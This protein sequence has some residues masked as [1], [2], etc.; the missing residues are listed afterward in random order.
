MLGYDVPKGYITFNKL[1]IFSLGHIEN[2]NGNI[3]WQF[4]KLFKNDVI[5]KLKLLNLINYSNM[6]LFI[7]Q[8]IGQ[9]HKIFT[10]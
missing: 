2:K 7:L 6:N 1:Y 5:N 4:N 9:Q 8:L 10:V 3:Q